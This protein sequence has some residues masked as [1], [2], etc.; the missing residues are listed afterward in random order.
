MLGLAS[1]G[2]NAAVGAWLAAAMV[3]GN[4]PKGVQLAT[5]VGSIPAHVS[6]VRLLVDVFYF[7]C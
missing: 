7:R 1:K 2:K 5:L 6:L 4:N 3:V